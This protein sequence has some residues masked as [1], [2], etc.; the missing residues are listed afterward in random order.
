MINAA[1]GPLPLMM[2]I[3]LACHSA[4]GSETFVV[5]G[6]GE[7]SI[8]LID[9]VGDQGKLIK[10]SHGS[11]SIIYDNR[12]VGVQP[13]YESYI[14]DLLSGA[15]TIFITVSHPGN[16]GHRSV[17]KYSI[18]NGQ[19]VLLGCNYFGGRTG[20]D[21]QNY[22]WRVDGKAK[23]AQQVD[24]AEPSTNAVPPSNPSGSAR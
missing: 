9:I 18:Q 6:H 20:N 22:I 12:S 19:I 5:D 4:C 13:I 16:G 21:I 17:I 14:V 11:S 15:P 7:F 3:I 2:T 1:F 8:N 23:T 24:S 10:L